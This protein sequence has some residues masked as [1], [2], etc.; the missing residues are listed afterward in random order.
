MKVKRPNPYWVQVRMDARA[1]EQSKAQ[2]DNYRP[3]M[4]DT[5]SGLQFSSKPVI[6][7]TPHAGFFQLEQSIFR[8]EFL[9]C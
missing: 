1:L 3:P 8:I 4:G 6:E 5:E 2:R 7:K 9:I